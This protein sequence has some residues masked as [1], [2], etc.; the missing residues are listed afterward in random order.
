MKTLYLT[1]AGFVVEDGE[2]LKA[3]PFAEKADE[4]ARLYKDILAGRVTDAIKGIIESE[5]SRDEEF[6]TQSPLLYD[7]LREMGYKVRL[8]ERKAEAIDLMVKSGMAK[9]ASEAWSRIKSI[10]EEVTRL[11]LKED[12]ANRDVMI[13]QAISAYEEAVEMINIMYERLREWYGVYFPEL[14]EAVRKLD[15]YVN[16]VANI[17]YKENYN[18]DVLAALGYSEERIKQIVKA[19]ESS[20]GTF[21]T[22]QDLNVIRLYAQRLKVLIDLR[23]ALDKYLQ[24][25]ISEVAPNL[26]ALIGYKIA[27]KLIAKAGGLM[28]LASLPASTIQLLGAEK[29]LFRALRRGTKPPKHGYIFQHP[30][31]NQSPKGIRGKIARTMASKIAIAA[32]A[33]AFGGEFIGDKLAEELRKKVE[34][35]RR[36]YREIMRRKELRLR[37]KKR[38]RR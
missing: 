31:I 29:A 33:D 28:K 35:L 1:P 19:A 17:T 34:E 14:A 25:L 23:D 20:V 9:D 21:L 2:K 32:R 10:L 8:V 5:V 37:R 4:S 22:E 18:P 7:Y 6:A 38:R 27:A 11:K 13:I 30:Y 3:L 26:Q 15:S 24:S 12:L 16:L 36:S